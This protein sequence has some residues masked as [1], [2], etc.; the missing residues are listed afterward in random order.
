M[1]VLWSSKNEGYSSHLWQTRLTFDKLG[2]LLRSDDLITHS[3]TADGVK[4]CVR[5]LD[6][7]VAALQ[8]LL[9]FMHMFIT[10]LV[11]AEQKHTSEILR[12]CKAE[13]DT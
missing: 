9:P 2:A 3:W 13:N 10:T 7:L 4:H 1:I 8:A 12:I 11:E 6:H 5:L